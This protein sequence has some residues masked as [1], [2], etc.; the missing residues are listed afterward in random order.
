M[1]TQSNLRA[2]FIVG[3]D[4]FEIVETHLVDDLSKSFLLKP[5]WK[6]VQ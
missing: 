4:A 1:T 5:L 3:P 2:T 6:P